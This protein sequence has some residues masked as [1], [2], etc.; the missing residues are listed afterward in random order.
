MKKIFLSFL[1]IMTIFSMSQA[2]GRV[3][4]ISSHPIPTQENIFNREKTILKT[5]EQQQE[6]IKSK[7][8]AKEKELKELKTSRQSERN[9]RKQTQ[10][11]KQE[12]INLKK[13]LNSLM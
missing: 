5:I 11:I 1:L 12:I 9:K 8:R 10:K 3:K 2:I 7:I 6:D 4:E 13:E